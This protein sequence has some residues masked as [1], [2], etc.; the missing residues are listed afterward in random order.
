LFLPYGTGALL[1]RDRR[2]LSASYSAELGN[3]MPVPAGD[4]LPDYARLST[5]L[6]REHRGL[7]VWL[8]LHLHGLGAFRTA[9]DEKLDLAG[10]LHS[11]L[12]AESRLDVLG[13]PDL[14]TVVFRL[15]DGG[16]DANQ[17]LLG[18]ILRAKRVYLSST[19]LDGRFTLRVCVLSHRT[20]REH[21]EELVLAIRDALPE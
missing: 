13:L 4:V 5:E 20:H 9:L 1:V 6:T 12:A 14:S 19:R 17:A 8:P 7:R 21:V 11:A 16:D 18:R 2:L 3:Y 15:R 10:H